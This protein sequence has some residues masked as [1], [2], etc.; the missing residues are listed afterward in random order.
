MKSKSIITFFFPV[1][2][3][4]ILYCLRE[5]NWS[6]YTNIAKEDSLLEYIQ[7]FLYLFSF[8]IIFYSL[9]KKAALF[10]RFEKA[11]L[12]ICTVG[13]FIMSMEE[14]SWGQ[15][16]LTFETPEYFLEQNSQFELNVHNL[17]PIQNIL[18]MLYA[19]VGL[20]F[21][22][23]LPIFKILIKKRA[24]TKYFPDFKTSLYFIFVS[25]FYL[26][27]QYTNVSAPESIYFIKWQDQEVFELLLALG[28]FI[29][30]AVR[31][32]KNSNGKS[33]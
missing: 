18:H 16:L 10:N 11:L 25:V 33:I 12:V 6:L 31:V 9:V 8:C 27:L 21:G 32:L 24:L 4:L 1:V 14:I 2:Y 15:R 3:I 13:F 20:A 26:L 28:L 5:L 23:V 29:G 7:F 19:A 22:V 30:F 17:K